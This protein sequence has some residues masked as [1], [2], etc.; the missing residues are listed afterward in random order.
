MK[1][2]MLIN[3]PLHA[4]AE[5]DNSAWREELLKGF[6]I[7]HLCHTPHDH[8]VQVTFSSILSAP[9]ACYTALTPTHHWRIRSLAVRQWPTYDATRRLYV[10]GEASGQLPIPSKIQHI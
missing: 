4:L 2:V 6:R 1:S 9:P 3:I 8:S 10:E 7:R 5:V